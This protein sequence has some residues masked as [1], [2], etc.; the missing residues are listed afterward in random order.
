[1]TSSSN[2][3]AMIQLSINILTFVIHRLSRICDEDQAL[4]WIDSLLSKYLG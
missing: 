2:G 3:T 1:M 4:M